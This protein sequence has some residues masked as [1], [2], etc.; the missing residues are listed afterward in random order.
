MHWY[1]PQI[2]LIMKCTLVYTSVTFWN[3]AFDWLSGCKYPPLKK[4]ITTSLTG[5]HFQAPPC[6]PLGLRLPCHSQLFIRLHFHSLSITVLPPGPVPV[7]TVTSLY[8]YCCVPPSREGMID[9][10]REDRGGTCAVFFS[11][12][13]SRG[14]RLFIYTLLMSQW[15]DTSET[16][17][18][19]VTLCV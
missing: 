4:Y 10:S 7:L 1:L 17:T 6:C 19:G 15:L 18:L 13:C 2:R 8:V 11:N 5:C 12:G 3:S 9:V 16:I 14:R